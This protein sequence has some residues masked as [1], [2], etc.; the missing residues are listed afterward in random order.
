M[1]FELSGLDDVQA[2]VQ[3]MFDRARQPRAFLE[4]EAPRLHAVIDRAWAEERSPSGEAWPPFKNGADGGSLRTAH[5][6]V[7]DDRG[8]TVVVP[9]EAAS[10]QFARRNPLPFERAGDGYVRAGE[11][12]AGHDER[13]RR[14]LS[15]EEESP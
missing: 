14:F 4:A 2:R 5:E 11:Y 1:G 7:I 10:F 3:R 15:G 8:L 13:L 6:V 9:H 12:W